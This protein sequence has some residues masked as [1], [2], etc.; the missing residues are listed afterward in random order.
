[1]RAVC[2]FR[3]IDE[4]ADWIVIDKPA[5]LAVH[6]SNGRTDE[7]TLLGGLEALLACELAG[8]GHLS[9][10]T[11]LDRETSGLVLVAKN[12]EAARWFS[13]QLE[14][15][16]A[17]KEYLAIVHGWP[18]RDEWTADG[19]ILRAGEVEESEIW[20]RQRVHPDG[21]D[22]RTRLRVEERF[23]NAG[24]RF[25]RVRCRPETG[26]M[27]QIRV[28]LADA[29]HAIAGDKIYAG[30]GRAYLEQ[31]AGGLSI[32]SAA[33]LILPR[34]ALHAARLAVEWRGARLVW[35][36]PL[37]PELARFVA[38]SGL[39]RGHGKPGETGPLP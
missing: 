6:P 29:G 36:S 14:R 1:M 11:R 32:E 15:R 37:A 27:H 9:I 38:P 34:Q 8:G 22:C 7:P 19:R 18:E 17:E 26:R 31:V 13:G 25:A 35:E 5:P 3:V 33:R 10:L 16:R 23:E 20:V 2:E 30:D 12:R 39:G 28:H 24:G 21:R 4:S